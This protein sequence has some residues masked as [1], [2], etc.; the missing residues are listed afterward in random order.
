MNCDQQR[1]V[2]YHYDE[3][4]PDARQAFEEHLTACPDCQKDLEELQGAT[5]LLRAWPDAEPA[6]N[7]VFVQEEAGAR[8]WSIPAWL[9]PA[10]WRRPAFG[11]AA[12]L[13]VV[14]LLALVGAEF[15]YE[16]GR[17]NLRL[18]LAPGS[19]TQM[20]ADELDQPATRRDLLSSQQQ[21]LAAQ[22]Q[23]LA[24]QQQLLSSQQ[25]SI[26]Y[27]SAMLRDSEDR[28]QR[29]FSLALTG[30]A[31]QFEQQRQQDQQQV[32]RHLQEFDW[33]TDSRFRR[34]EGVLQRLIPAVQD[35]TYE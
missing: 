35:R 6:A 12:S 2:D 16:D 9:R 8:R 31:R 34:S 5:R 1:L 17:L 4:E 33:Y 19:Q 27:I 21:L 14:L 13:A 32:G 20:V 29:E 15:S 28:Q 22:R 7:L 25:Q 11:M 23:L 26:E 3:L 24:S 10:S 18:D 30:L